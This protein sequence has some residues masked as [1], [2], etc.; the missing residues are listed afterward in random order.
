M[1]KSI[2]QDEKVC[3]LTGSTYGLDRHHVIG[4]SRRSKAEKWGCWVWLRHD[5]H[6]DLHERDQGMSRILKATCQKRFEEL[7][8]HDKWMSEFGKN[9]LEVEDE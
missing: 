4:G 8:G 9:Y 3:F 7:Y 1:A 6:M 5:V 2:M